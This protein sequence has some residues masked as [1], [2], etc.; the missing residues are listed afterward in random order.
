MPPGFVAP[1][2]LLDPNPLPDEPIPEL[3]MPLGPLFE[4]LFEKPRFELPLF[5]G[6]FA[7]PVAEPF[8]TPPFVPDVLPSPPGA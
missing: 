2:L 1:V 5:V 6:L 4:P 3:P 7:V 8:A